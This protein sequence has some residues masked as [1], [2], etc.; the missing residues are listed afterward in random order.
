MDILLNATWDDWKVGLCVITGF[1]SLQFVSSIARYCFNITVNPFDLIARWL[2]PSRC[3]EC[4]N[5]IEKC[6][7]FIHLKNYKNEEN[8]DD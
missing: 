3:M 5:E 7:C 2:A 6:S 8:P 1:L 4:K